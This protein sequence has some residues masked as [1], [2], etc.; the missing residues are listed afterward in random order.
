[1]RTVPVNHRRKVVGFFVLVTIIL[2]VALFSGDSKVVKA[3]NNSEQ[4]VFSTPG[5]FMSLTSNTE[6]EGTPFGFWI[7]CAASPSPKSAP[8]TYQ[9]AQVCQGSMYFYFLGVPEHVAS[10]F[11]VTENTD[12]IYTFAVSGKDFLCTL[13]NET[14]NQG[15]H[16]TV[17][18]FCS[19]SS[20]F[21]GGT[22]FASVTNAT[23][24][25]TGP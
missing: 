3:G 6:Y 12:G 13:H 2:C 18:V 19:F 20:K 25:T 10:D 14:T 5:S 4:L 24:N 22:G 1:M 15:P 23:V 17:D 11:T 9:A 8:P 21:G 7:W 16:D